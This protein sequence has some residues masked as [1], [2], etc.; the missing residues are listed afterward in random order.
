MTVASRASDCRVK[1]TLVW[2]GWRIFW[3]SGLG[4]LYLLGVI[5]GTFG[6]GTS[7]SNTLGRYAPGFARHLAHP[8]ESADQRRHIEEPLHF[9]KVP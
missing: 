1:V 6:L 7:L 2:S 3:M 9:R 8:E 5:F 4:Y